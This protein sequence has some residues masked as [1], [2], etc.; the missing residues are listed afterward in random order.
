MS[1]FNRGCGDVL[2]NLGTGRNR[3]TVYSFR[4][5]RPWKSADSVSIGGGEIGGQYIHSGGRN[6]GTVYSFR[7]TRPWKSADSVSIGTGNLGTV[8]PFL[9]LRGNRGTVYPFL[10][11]NLGKSGDS[12]SISQSKFGGSVT[13]QPTSPFLSLVVI[14]H[15][16]G[17]VAYRDVLR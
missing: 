12:V 2:G 16:V 8:Y 1:S 7:C 15:C 6:R 9:N 4:C 13:G 11:L 3:G 5:T 14:H 10:N 17:R